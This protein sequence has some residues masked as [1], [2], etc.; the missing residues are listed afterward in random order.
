MTGAPLFIEVIALTAR[1]ACEAEAAGADRIELVSDMAQGGLTPSAQ[2]VDEVVRQ[3]RLP[4]MVMVRPH[5]RSFC[6]DEADMRQVREGVAMVRD[7]GAHGLVFGALMA[8]GDIDRA[9]LDQVLRWADGLPMTFHRAFDEARD[10]VRAFSE[11]S[12]YRGAVTQLLSSGAAPT[13]EEGAELLAQ[14]VTRW[15]LGEG[16]EPL[17]GAGVHAGNLAALHRRIGARQYHVGSGARAGGSFASGIDAARIAALR[18][19][20]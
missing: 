9:A 15:R 1:D 3:C 19:A 12:A 10:P 7:A 18:Q 14:L 5:A 13:A 8:D 16:V 6:Y 2:V 17:V 20:L 11:L 4:V